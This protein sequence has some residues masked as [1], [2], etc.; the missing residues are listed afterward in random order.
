MIRTL[1]SAAALFFLGAGAAQAAAGDCASMAKLN[2]PNVA[3][4]S[5]TLVPA[6]G[7]IEGAF[8][9]GLTVD[10]AFCRVKATAT[11]TS[12]SDI[13]MEVWLPVGETWNGKYLQIGNGG[14]AGAVPVAGMVQGLR[15]GYAVAATDDGNQMGGRGITAEWALGHPEKIVDF[16]YRAV[17][18][19]TLAAKTVILNFYGAR[20]KLS[21]FNG[22]STGG[23][24][25][26]M[27]AQR[28]PLSFDGIIAGA[29]AAPFLSLLNTGALWEK[30]MTQPGA[31]IPKEKLP[32]LQKAALAAC[33]NGKS[34]IADPE[35]CKFDPARIQCRGKDSVD[36]LTKAQV[37]T[38]RMLYN[39]VRD[40]SINAMLPGTGA[41]AEAQ[42]GS[43]ANWI[44][45][46]APGR[47]A[48]SE[49]FPRNFYAFMV[50]NK[51]DLKIE[52]ITPA[53]LAKGRELYSA[54]MDATEPDLSAFKAR[55]GKLIQYHGWNDAAIPAGL[56][57]NYFNQVQATMGD[58]SDFY[59]LF[60]VPGLLHCRGGAA[61]TEIVWLDHLEDWVERGKAPDA[62]VATGANGDAQ[63][64]ERRKPPK[65]K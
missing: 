57:V 26:L 35:R 52:E 19:T 38:A 18:Q 54:M 9:P 23:R 22:C 2:I 14:Y 31:W 42:P 46:T 51:P 58:T 36:C 27:S 63:T 7:A 56:S 5:A 39:G 33:G 25:A 47:G 20:E 6:N 34:Y 11:P 13:R 24:E 4:T 60:M 50:L 12:D 3:I 16:A 48:A 40:P 41:G 61:P 45:G 37:A 28:Y 29:P 8:M 65:K 10:F 62:L 49:A 30:H 15:R 53:D 44:V 64:L 32:A 43:W 17:N 21:Y 59:R 55:G 1:L